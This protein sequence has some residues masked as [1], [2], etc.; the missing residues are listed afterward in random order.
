MKLK[1][2]Y[3]M[4]L[5]I[6]FICLG[7]N[8]GFLFSEPINDDPSFVQV[9]NSANKFPVTVKSKLLKAQPGDYIITEQSKNYSILSIRS[10]SNSTMVLEEISIPSAQ[11][12]ALKNS[13]KN[14]VASNAPGHTSWI[15]YEIDLEND[16]LIE[17]F[18]ISKQGWLFFNESE[19]FFTKLIT[20]PLSKTPEGQKRRIGPPPAPGEMDHRH[21]WYPAMIFEGKKVDKPSY[22]VWHGIWPNDDTLLSGC[23]IELYFGQ[24]KQSFPF[25]Y[26]IDISNANYTYKIRV[27]DSGRGLLSP[28]SGSIPHR[29]PEFIGKIQNLGETFRLTLKAPVY[30]KKFALF[31]IDLTVNGP[32]L[33]VPYEKKP[34][35][36]QDQVFLEVT[37]EDLKSI[38]KSDHKYRW[39]AIGEGASDAYAE[40]EEPFLWKQP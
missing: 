16:Q 34:G 15:L 35:P 39:V 30:Y 37:R 21:I 17:C 25:P 14:W 9:A 19:H 31:A 24:G 8:F 4:Y 5:S 40:T 23:K 12:S 38:L 36:Q 13:W 28:F 11:G 26:W 6:V 7:I 1:I 27:V 10:L 29:P 3:S 32:P 18:S 33:P 2:N 22:E 20:L